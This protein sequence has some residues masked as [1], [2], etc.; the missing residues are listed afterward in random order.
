MI[1][2]AISKARAVPRAKALQHVVRKVSE[3]RPVFLVTYDPRLPSIPAIQHKHWRAMVATDQY[4]AEVFPEPP[5]TAFR[6]HKNIGEYFIRA[7]VPPPK[8][9]SKR[10]IKG[11]TKC[12]KPCQASEHRA[13][14]TSRF[15][16]K[17]SRIHFNQRG[18]S[19]SDVRITILEKR[20]HLT[21]ANK[22]KVKDP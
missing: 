1:D 13:K 19:I 21:K 18:H 10:E 16:T 14:I 2:G 15:T 17:A 11:M 6:R 9:R 8:S 3:R 5:L 12:N 20:R 7:K 22:K 4:I